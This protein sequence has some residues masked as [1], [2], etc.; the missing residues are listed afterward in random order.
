MKPVKSPGNGFS[1]QLPE[2]T[3]LRD[4]TPGVR[5]DLCRV[6]NPQNWTA[7]IYSSSRAGLLLHPPAPTSLEPPGQL[8]G[9][10]RLAH[11]RGS[12]SLEHRRFGSSRREDQTSHR[13][14]GF[15]PNSVNRQVE[16]SWLGA[17]REGG[18]HEMPQGF[19]D[20]RVNR[21]TAQMPAGS[22]WVP[23]GQESGLG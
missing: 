12:L 20:W 18:S 7:T 2:G 9:L 1:L 16:F 21:P 6:S 14:P 11:L 23:S 3:Q 5:G 10:P 17:K 13:A 15:T 22:G 4:P 8:P 19:R